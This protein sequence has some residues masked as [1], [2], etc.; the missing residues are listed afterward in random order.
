MFLFCW[1]F[2]PLLPRR[3]L[4]HNRLIQKRKQKPLLLKAKPAK[5]TVK[6]IAKKN[7]QKNANRNAKKTVN[8]IRQNAQKNVRRVQKSVQQN[9]IKAM[10]T[11]PNAAK[12]KALTAV[13]VK[14]EFLFNSILLLIKNPGLGR[15]FLL[16]KSVCSQKVD[17]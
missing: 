16:Y 12:K 17:I 1:F 13:K 7:V 9:V 6:P 2:L 8:A 14:T 10:A 4:F 11:A 15:D 3:L 5:W